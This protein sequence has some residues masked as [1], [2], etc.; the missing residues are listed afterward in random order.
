MIF[1]ESIS[2]TAKDAAG[3]QAAQ[4]F[5]FSGKARNVFVH[6]ES[7]TGPVEISFTGQA[8][9]GELGASK[10]D[11]LVMEDFPVSEIWLRSTNADEVVQVWAWGD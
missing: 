4:R 3:W 7:G 10:P 5:S 1:Y 6:V 11:D 2:V 8:L 9:H